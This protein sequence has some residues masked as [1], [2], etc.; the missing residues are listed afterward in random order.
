MSPSSYANS[1]QRRTFVRPIPFHRRLLTLLVKFSTKSNL[2]FILFILFLLYWLNKSSTPAT[3]RTN[4]PVRRNGTDLVP[5][6][7][8]FAPTQIR[9]PAAVITFQRGTVQ[10]LHTL[11]RSRRTGVLKQS[12]TRVW[13][14]GSIVSIQLPT[15]GALRYTDDVGRARVMRS[16]TTCEDRRVECDG[17]VEGTLELDVMNALQEMRSSGEVSLLS[18]LDQRPWTDRMHTR[19][20]M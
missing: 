14:E 13:N 16:S 15:G 1:R 19:A 7:V 3:R 8:E 12:Y 2:S 20:M 11:K 18:F 9:S 5:T 6:G 4:I 17:I 10:E